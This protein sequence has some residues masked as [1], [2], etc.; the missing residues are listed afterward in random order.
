VD[1]NNERSNNEGRKNNEKRKNK[2]RG[3]ILKKYQKTIHV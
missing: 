3:I 2:T 1:S